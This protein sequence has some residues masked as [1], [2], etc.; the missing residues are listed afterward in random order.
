MTPYIIYTI[1]HEFIH[2]LIAL[3]IAYI[4]Y[5]KFGRRGLIVVF[6]VSFLVDSDHLVDLLVSG[7]SNIPS[8]L[9]NGD[10]FKGLTKKY[11]PFH[12]FELSTALFIIGRLY[13]KHEWLFFS[14]SLALFYHLI[15]DVVSYYE[16]GVMPWEYLIL[17][18]LLI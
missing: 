7:V 3:P 4:C 2:L 11:L 6:L 12:S 17:F 18:R 9:I 14:A 16:K 15:V 1:Y 13:R 8:R 10:L 5:Q